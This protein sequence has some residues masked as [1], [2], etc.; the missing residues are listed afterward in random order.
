MPKGCA[1]VTFFLTVPWRPSISECAGPILFTFSEQVQIWVDMINPPSDRYRSRDVAIVTDF[2]R[3]SAKWH[4]PT[5][6]CA[7]TFHNGW[8]DL[9]GARVNRR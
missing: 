7:L 8:E 2:W 6:F 9:M 4:T 3:E 5:S 1:D